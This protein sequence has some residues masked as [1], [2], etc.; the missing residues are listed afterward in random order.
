MND[1]LRTN[2]SV[3]LIVQYLHMQLISNTIYVQIK[4][5]FHVRLSVLMACKVYVKALENLSTKN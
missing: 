4:A 5:K 3:A 2:T 1:H